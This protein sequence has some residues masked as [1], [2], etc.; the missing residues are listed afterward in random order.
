MKADRQFFTINE[1]T[2]P[3]SL[4]RRYRALSK[5][6]HPDRGG[7]D[8]IQ[9]QI[10]DQYQKALKQLFVMA[11][12]KGDHETANEV[13]HLIVQHL[14]NLI[15]DVKEPI[16]R[17]YVPEQFQGLALEVAKLIEEQMK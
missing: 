3:E 12:G 10:N 2:T 16:I 14:R 6:Y 13:K 7:S 17:R 4:K 11:S 8:D 5:R 1:S 9:A 15:A